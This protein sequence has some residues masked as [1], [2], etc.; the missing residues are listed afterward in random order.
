[1]LKVARVETINLMGLD[2][3]ELS[4]GK[5]ITLISGENASCKT[6]LVEAFK[7]ALAT[8]TNRRIHDA[9]LI[10][11]GTEEARVVI[12]FED[13]ETGKKHGTVTVT[14]DG[15]DYNRE[16][17]T[18]T[19]G[20]IG[21]PA[22]WLGAI[23][24][25]KSANPLDFL[26]IKD[27]KERAKWLLESVRLELNAEDLAADTGFSPPEIQELI[28]LHPLEALRRAE[29]AINDLRRHQNVRAEELRSTVKTLAETAPKLQV[30]GVSSETVA[31]RR[32]DHADLTEKRTKAKAKVSDEHHNEDLAAE[33][34]KTAAYQKADK[35]YEDALAAIRLTRDA[36]R[37]EADQACAKRTKEANDV[38]EAALREI[39]ELYGPQI[40]TA[41]ES[42]AAAERSLAEAGKVEQSKQAQKKFKDEAEAAEALSQQYTDRLA[43]LQTRRQLLMRQNPLP[44]TEV[45][46]DGSILVGGVPL[47][48]LNTGAAIDLA[49][50]LAE[51]RAGKAP[52]ICLDG[53]E[54]VDPD[55]QLKIADRLLKSKYQF[56]ITEVSLGP[57]R[58]REIN[59]V[60]DLRNSQR[61]NAQMIL[62]RKG[63]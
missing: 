41:A 55:H 14:I 9:S 29:K 32:K 13:E 19:H 40:D 36:A 2:F 11:T 60:D 62:N 35:E 8:G 16:I 48:R 37:L 15:E 10:R 28:K 31:T 47:D 54:A 46:E 43:N 24:D 38:S 42:L 5:A 27:A 7:A 61:E 4:P 30:V 50:R 21:A 20:T 12:E 23:V 56:I 57:L 52:F 58:S 39:D 33:R 44:D 6:S 17:S 45:A 49:V 51:Y 25:Y 26:K 1:M 63:E 22:T 3:F 59:T 53:W 18:P 34:E